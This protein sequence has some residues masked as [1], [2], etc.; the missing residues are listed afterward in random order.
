[1]LVGFLIAIVIAIFVNQ[2]G[3]T[4]DNGK[5]ENWVI[6]TPESK[7]FSA[8]FPSST[9]ATTM[10]IPMPGSKDSIRQETVLSIDRAENVYYVITLAYPKTF[11]VDDPKELLAAGL[12]GMVSS[13][14][15]GKLIDSKDTTFKDLP[16]LAFTIQS[17]NGLHYQG[18]LTVKDNMVYQ[19]FKTYLPE[20]LSADD[21]NFFLA[22]FNPGVK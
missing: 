1:M 12:Q 6:L 11:K 8:R 2:N 4:S 7:S 18:V 10:D 19:A 16:A 21:L 3:T 9:Q 15:G 22:S 14:K 5:Y 17:E 20:T 13:V